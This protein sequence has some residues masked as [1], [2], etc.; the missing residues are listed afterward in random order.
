MKRT[1]KLRSFVYG[2]AAV[3]V[4]RAL[5]AVL[6]AQPANTNDT[7]EVCASAEGVMRL[8]G[9]GEACGA[10]ERRLLLNPPELETP[11]E[12]PR[13]DVSGLERRLNDLEGL[14]NPR[15]LPN[16]TVMPFEVLNEAG[17]RVFAVEEFNPG[18]PGQIVT[19]FYNET[20][21]R[22]A[23]IS[24]NAEGGSLSVI[25]ATSSPL[26]A[27]I[28]ARGEYADV[29]IHDS[30]AQ[31]RVALG[32]RLE[33]NG[34]YSLQVFGR[35]GKLVA[36][37]GE[38]EAGSGVAIVADAAGNPRMSMFRNSE[39]G[40]GHV[41]ITNAAGKQVATLS[42]SGYGN[43]GLLRLSNDAGTDM[44]QAGVTDTGVGAVIAGPAAF[45]QGLMFIGLPGSYIAGRQ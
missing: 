44:V 3:V 27:A 25:S 33:N 43:S 26:S 2:V 40:G 10:G 35:G 5:L 13:R 16:R 45:Q 11:C 8:T 32:R 42:G 14:I 12:Q 30:G 28:T 19:E 37:I 6:A 23:V 20:G 41:V 22:V 21:K 31:R 17:I 4:A 15:Q 29:E 7:V 39:S 1:A 38:S 34:R 9:S 36:G 24:A 18:V